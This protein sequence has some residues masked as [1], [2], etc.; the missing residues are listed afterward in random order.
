LS[1]EIQNSIRD[2]QLGM[3][4]LSNETGGEAFYNLDGISG[5]LTKMLDGSSIYYRLAYPPPSGKNPKKYHSIN[6]SVK[7]HP[8]YHVRTQ[9]GY[10]LYD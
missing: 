3:A 5:Q 4:I 1:S 10:Y 6:V 9:K 8:E 7:D 2:Y